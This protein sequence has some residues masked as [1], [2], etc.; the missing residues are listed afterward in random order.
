[1]L[2]DIMIYYSNPERVTRDRKVSQL[3]GHYLRS[4]QSQHYFRSRVIY[5]CYRW[6]LSHVSLVFSL[7]QLS[8]YGR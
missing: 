2:V 7:A 6:R 4:L 1:M 3:P 5:P 8:D